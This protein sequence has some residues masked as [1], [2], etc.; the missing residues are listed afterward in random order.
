MRRFALISISL[1]VLGGLIAKAQTAPTILAT[2]DFD[3]VWRL[4]G[5]PMGTLKADDSKVAQVS[6]GKHLVQAATADGLASFRAVVEVNQGQEVVEITLRAAH[7]QNAAFAGNEG[8]TWID[9]STRLMWAR[10][11]NGEDVSWQQAAN[12][13]H[14]LKL[15]GFSNWRLPTIDELSTIYDQTQNENGRHIRGGIQMNGFGGWSSSLTKRSHQ[16]W[17]FYFNSG[18]RGF[19]E[20]SYNVNLRAICVRQNAAPFTGGNDAK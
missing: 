7:D 10:S 17:A 8:H 18:T 5:Q 20:L 1:L 9:L 3:C 16:A 15:D 12:Y 11:D 14:N 6:P 2:T 19:F 4:D 13:C